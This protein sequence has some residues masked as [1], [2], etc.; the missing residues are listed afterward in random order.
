MI[1]THKLIIFLTTWF[2]SLHFFHSA[3]AK[4]CSPSAC[5]AIRN[6]SNPFRLNSDPIHCGSPNFELTCENNVTFIYLDSIKYYV[7]AI[8]Y[9]SST[10]RLVDASI[11]NDDICSFPIHSSYPYPYYTGVEWFVNFISCPGP[12][13]NS[14]NIFINI[15]QDC[16]SNLSHPIFSYVFVGSMKTSKLPHMCTLD[17]IVQTSGSRF[18]DQNVSLL[19]IHQSLLDGLE[20]N[21]CY[22]C[23]GKSTIWGFVVCCAAII[24]CLTAAL[25]PLVIITIGTGVGLALFFILIH[26]MYMV[27]EIRYLMFPSLITGIIIWVPRIIICPLIFWFLIYKFRRRRLSSF[28]GVESFLQS[29]NKLA[30]IS[31]QIARKIW[32]K[33]A[34]LH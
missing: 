13:K 17:L 9:Y 18:V 20:I 8:N 2:L 19:E 3:E 27:G 16:A 23:N 29:D 12:M 32:S 6:I 1:T 15:T 24:V 25:N 22:N 31:S 14:S 7:K 26:S 33:R 30:P 21:F 5:G 10:I 34:R 28:E 4:K 11:N